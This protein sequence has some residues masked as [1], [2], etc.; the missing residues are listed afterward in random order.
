[1]LWFLGSLRELLKGVGDS[2]LTS[3]ASLRFRKGEEKTPVL[4]Q[5]ESA[6]D[7]KIRPK[8]PIVFCS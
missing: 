8:L 7:V 1:M 4:S 6:E 3:E 2:S 5:K